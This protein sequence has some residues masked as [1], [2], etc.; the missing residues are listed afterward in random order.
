MHVCVI[1][2]VYDYFLGH[3]PIGGEQLRHYYCALEFQAV[4][5]EDR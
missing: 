4:Q 2:A 1:R 5:S 3:H